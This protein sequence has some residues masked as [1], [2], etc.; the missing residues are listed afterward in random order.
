MLQTF[1]VATLEVSVTGV[2]EHELTGPAGV[3]VG[4]V[5]TLLSTRSML[6]APEDPDEVVSYLGAIKGRK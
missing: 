6:M 3:I 2:V 4:F 1:P 5:T